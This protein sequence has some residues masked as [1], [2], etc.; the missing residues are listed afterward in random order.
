MDQTALDAVDEI[1]R[2]PG[3]DISVVVARAMSTMFG[4]AGIKPFANA[5]YR[6]L[7]SG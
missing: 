2:A 5:W 6:R 3:R 4:V 7:L 1:S